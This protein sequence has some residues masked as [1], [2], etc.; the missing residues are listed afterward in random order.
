MRF[1]PILFCGLLLTGAALAAEQA[2][3]TQEEIAL[4]YYQPIAEAG[5][6]LAQLTLG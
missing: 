6:P 3:L 4:G 5:E 1:V 2:E